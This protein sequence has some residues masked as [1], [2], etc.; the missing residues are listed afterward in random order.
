MKLIWLAWQY[1][2]L[3]ILRCI[4]GGAE[5]LPAPSLRALACAKSSGTELNSDCNVK[6]AT[7]NVQNVCMYIYI[8]IRI[9]NIIY[10]L[11]V[12]C[13]SCIYLYLFVSLCLGRIL[14]VVQCGFAPDFTTH[15]SRQALGLGSGFK[16]LVWP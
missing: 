5:S 15:R 14:H 3:H 10:V 11:F 9:L 4:C 16:G 13:T 8:Y 2:R 7:V 12:L 1:C 6:N